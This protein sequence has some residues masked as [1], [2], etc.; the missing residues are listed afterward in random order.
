MDEKIF[1]LVERKLKIGAIDIVFLDDLK[2]VYF[3]VFEKSQSN[4]KS[5][6]SIQEI[7]LY[8]SAAVSCINILASVIGA[9]DNLECLA[10]IFTGIASIISV[11]VTV[12]LGKKSSSKYCET[13]LRH[14]NHKTKLEFEIM[15]Y[16]FANGKY[17]QGNEKDLAKKF[18]ENILEIRKENQRIFEQNM[19]NYDVEK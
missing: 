15:D 17:A 1:E 8:G 7:I 9:F 5:H 12:Y 19:S 6:F 2:K 10:P 18:V 16:A 3:D 11:L 14:Q 4:K 13:W